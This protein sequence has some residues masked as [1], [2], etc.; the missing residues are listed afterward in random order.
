MGGAVWLYRPVHHKLAYR[1]K[2]RVIAIGPQ[3]QAVLREFFTPDLQAYLFSP[4]RA[5]EELHA[6]RALKEEDPALLIAHGEERREARSP[7]NQTASRTL[8]SPCV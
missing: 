7:T 8:L 3:A 4:C 1:G 6:E 5:V 2:R